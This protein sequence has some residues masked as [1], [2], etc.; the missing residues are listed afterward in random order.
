M[1]G[2]VYRHLGWAGDTL[3]DGVQGHVQTS[4]QLPDPLN[5]PILVLGVD[6]SDVVDVGGELLVQ[7][8]PLHDRLDSICNV[9]FV[10]TLTWFLL[11][12]SSLVMA[13]RRQGQ[14]GSMHRSW[15]AFSISGLFLV[16]L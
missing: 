6:C 1:S 5:S 11:S 8:I 16:L 15:R 12:I 14:A 2:S 9:T 10:K 4:H 3:G 7:G 13:S